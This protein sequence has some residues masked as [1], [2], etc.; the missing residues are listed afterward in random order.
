MEKNKKEEKFEYL[1][2]CYDVIKPIKGS[3]WQWAISIFISIIFSL[4]YACNAKT[5]SLFSECVG[6]INNIFLAVIAMEMGAYALFQALLSD[7]LVLVLYKYDKEMLDESN[8]AFLGVIL[9]YWSSIFLNLIIITVIKVIPE[10]FL[11][12]NSIMISEGIAFVLMIIYFS[13]SM[14]VFFEV[15]NFAINLYNV[16]KAYNRVSLLN[17]MKKENE[18]QQ[19]DNK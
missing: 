11:M 4:L 15:R 2:K 19:K 8:I 9:L 12:S 6:V 14:R 16:F 17:G 13:F 18:S 7:E 1:K 5:V 10:N 3:R